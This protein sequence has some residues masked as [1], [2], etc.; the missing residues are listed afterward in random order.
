M[1]LLAAVCVA[2]TGDFD[3]SLTISLGGLG[4]TTRQAPRGWT[5]GTWADNAHTFAYSFSYRQ[6]LHRML[7][8][9][10][11]Y[12]NQGHY[13]DGHRS[14][15]HS[16]DDLQ[17]ELFVGKRPAGGPV[18]FR[19]GGGGAYYSET[20]LLS[21]GSKVFLNHQGF[22][23]VVTGAVDFDISSRL[24]VEGRVHR[25]LVL[26]RY[27]STNALVGMGIRLRE[28][29]VDER[30]QAAKQAIALTYGLGRL[31]STKSETLKHAFQAAYEVE[32]SKHVSASVAY[33][34][35]GTAPELNRKGVVLQGAIRRSLGGPFVVGMAL[36]PYINVDQSDFFRR[37]DKIS[38]DALLTVFMDVAVSRHAA[39]T[40]SAGRPRS[41]STS[42]DKP[43]TDVILGGLKF[44]F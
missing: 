32:V 38:A 28:R 31:N 37:K 25:H 30:R 12:L 34:E 26:N 40:F 36:G 4:G 42:K 33:L 20:D 22:G 23:A 24:F 8:G 15:H 39:L 41:L 27:P 10:V 43:M 9:A 2:Q 13:D 44:R 1:H 14:L 7:S 29:V 6:Q 11:T 3:R 35:E 5:G 19:V 16:R 18:E 17:V 21:Q